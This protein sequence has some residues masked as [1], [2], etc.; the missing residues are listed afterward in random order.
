MEFGS[1]LGLVLIMNIALGALGLIL[2]L[3][4]TYWVIRL[5]VTHALRSHHYWLQKNNRA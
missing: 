3:L 5:A 2:G 1:Q 4:V